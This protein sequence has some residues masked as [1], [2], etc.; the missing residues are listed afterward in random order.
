[1]FRKFTLSVALAAAL[2]APAAEACTRVV[3]LGPEG[4]VLTGRSMDWSMPMVSNLWVFPRGMTRDGA[5]GPRSL[6]WT[7]K[8]GSMIVSGYDI[9]TVDG[10]N[11][12]GLVA[13]MLWLADSQYPQ[14]D[15]RTPRMSLSLWAQ[16]FLDRFATVEEAVAWL[17]E[18][19]LDVVT[20]DVPVQPG[21]LTTVHLSLSDAT[22]DSAI[23]EW[24][25]GK[26]VIHHGR[27]YRVM[28]NDPPYDEQ[29]AIAAYWKGVNPRE[30]M[31]GTSRAAD[32]F[33]RAGTFVDMV[34]Q[35]DDPRTAAAAVFS[36]VR[37]A[38]VPY[39]VS[40]PDAPNLSTTRWRVVADHK[41]RL[42]HVES[43]ISPNVFSVDLGKL[44]FAEGSGVRKLDLGMD[45]ERIQSGEVSAAFVAAD[46]FAFEPAD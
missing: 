35:S 16:F 19:P 10:M 14:D 7:S 26:L 25:A 42:F 24:L 2:A 30:A 20:K 27:G 46:P 12:Q 23:L 45:M 38:S 4:R 21:K 33:V 13:N 17:N 36:V 40:I 28:T 43:A 32:R 8:Y 18:N 5:A 11:E 3:Y 37:N 39:G 22:G 6:E 1:M 41:D 9:A 34:V 15:G 44:D 31:P 29:L